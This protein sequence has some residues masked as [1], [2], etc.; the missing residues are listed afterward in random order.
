MC[1]IT[2]WRS[3][4]ERIE[5]GMLRKIAGAIAHR[6]PDS[7]GFY[8]D[9]GIGFGFRRLAIIDLS[10]KGNQ[11][12]TSTTGKSTIIFNGEIYN[13]QELRTLDILRSYKFRSATD[14]EA[15]MALYEVVGEKC[16]EYLRGMF[17]FA[18]WDS[19]KKKLFIARDR[20]GK[21]PV[22]YYY[23]HGTFLFASE[24]KALLEHPALQERT[25]N[26]T[27]LQLY[28]K[29]GYVPAPYSIFNEIKKLPAAST[30]T[31]DKQGQ[32]HIS[33]YWDLDF[34]NKTPL[35]FQSAAVQLRKMIE[36]SVQLRMISDVP[37]GAFLSGGIDSSAVVATMAK[38]STKP[39]KTFSIGFEDKSYDELSFAK[40]VAEKYG[41]EHHEHVLKPDF[42]KDMP[43]IMRYFDEPFADGSAIPT[44]YIAKATRQHVTVALNG[45]GGDENFAGYGRYMNGMRARFIRIPRLPQ[46]DVPRTGVLRKI[47]LLGMTQEERYHSLHTAFEPAHLGYG[48]LPKFHHY[49]KPK[50]L[51]DKWMYA[52]IK[53]YLPD[54]LLVKVDRA[55]MANS[56][57]GRSPLLDHK[58]M[59]FS[60]SLPPEWKLKGTETK[61][62]FKH[63]V[64]DLLPK[65]IL[66]KKKQ[67]FAVP[68][69]EWMTK[70]WFSYTETELMQ[71]KLLQDRLKVR[72]LLDLQKQGK[73]YGYRLWNL[74]MLREWE[75]NYLVA[76]S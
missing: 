43:G 68:I 29:Y 5:K 16:V 38:F 40:I 7:D 71:S 67:G 46:S 44:Y 11:P 70:D 25:V 55:T 23:A 65:E 52:D 37:L 74:L 6:G 61:I 69:N 8:I 57:E 21:K 66:M 73:P 17:A 59:E 28:L 63:A 50:L 32:L 76:S 51:L 75:K 58:L 14:T 41:T 42:F 33:E 62:I 19:E 26:D 72:K 12:M 30:L 53:T 10:P 31:L 39:V 60:A 3:F 2:G 15:I 9:D 27:A 22:Y 45:D 18:I 54:D 49:A 35:N 4:T 20:L 24:I 36:E 64:K 56:L 1:G 13:Y 34:N 48:A 47:A